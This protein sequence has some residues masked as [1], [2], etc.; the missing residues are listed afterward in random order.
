MMVPNSSGCDYSE[1]RVSTIMKSLFPPIA[2]VVEMRGPGDPERLLPAE[3]PAVERAVPSRVQ[4]FA[5]GRECARRA[6]A[7]FDIA[8]FPI[9]AAPDRQP[10]WP[11]WMV[12]SIT[13]TAGY[14]AAV[15]AP[16]RVIAAI[17]IDCEG[18]GEVGLDI[19]PTICVPEEEAWVAS[20]PEAQKAA[21]VAFLFSAKEAF[22]KCQYPSTGQWLNFHDLH[23]TTEIWGGPAGRFNVHP[24]QPPTCGEPSHG[25]LCGRYLFHE[26][27]VTTGIALG[28]TSAR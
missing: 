16:K 20:L 5:A 11:A 4:E 2:V 21:A 26:G 25:A 17:G 23:I 10:I 18:A 8:D 3:A 1:P 22:Y 7:E 6:L 13:H 12:G 19:W 9:R 24:L 28:V 15:V 14:C 27:F